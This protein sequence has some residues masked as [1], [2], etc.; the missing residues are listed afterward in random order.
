MQLHQHSKVL[1]LAETSALS[2]KEEVEAKVGFASALQLRH[3]IAKDKLE[4]LFNLISGLDGEKRQ[5]AIGL[6]LNM[7]GA[8]YANPAALL[9]AVNLGAV[10]V[11]PHWNP[12]KTYIFDKTY[13]Q[14]PMNLWA[15]WAIENLQN[16]RGALDAHMLKVYDTRDNEDIVS[17]HHNHEFSGTPF[18]ADLGEAA[19]GSQV[20]IFQVP[21][22]KHIKGT[23]SSVMMSPVSSS[24]SR[25]QGTHAAL[26]KG[27]AGKTF[28]ITKLRAKSLIKITEDLTLAGD[29]HYDQLLGSL[30]KVE[31]AQSEMH[32]TIKD[33]RLNW[34][35]YRTQLGQ[36]LKNRFGK[37]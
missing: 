24:H 16:S 4:Q 23:D 12:S 29:S 6:L 34:H 35:L 13:F 33:A 27:L 25:H 28:N 10:Q 7:A 8:A 36:E 22:N 1:V 9:D 21:E 26:Q 17:T 11:Q 31:L 5:F 14:E 18:G 30:E 15:G 3:K 19:S 37:Y 2:L 20:P 32:K